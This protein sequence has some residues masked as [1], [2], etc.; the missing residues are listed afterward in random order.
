[1][2]RVI[3]DQDNGS[4]VELMVDEAAG[5]ITF[6]VE[7]DLDEKI[8]FKLDAT[9]AGVLGADLARMARRLA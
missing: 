3:S 6:I 8:A 4:Y 1:M 5:T 2:A 7:N 9:H